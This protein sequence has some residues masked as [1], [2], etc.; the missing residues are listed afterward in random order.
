MPGNRELIELMQAIASGD[1]AGTS[2]RLTAQPDLAAAQLA[3]GSSKTADEFF[4]AEVRLQIYVGDSALHVAAAAYDVGMAEQL[5]AAGADVRARNRRGAEPIH[6][7]MTG[8]PGSPTWD[9][10]RQAAMIAYLVEVGA[11][12]NARAA[13]GVTPLH[14]AVRN[15]CSAAVARLLELGADP[16]LTN[17]SGSTALSLAGHTTGRGGSGS[18]QAKAEQAAILLLLEAA[19]R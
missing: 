7:A 9:P 1:A 10:L 13:G 3:K 4:L 2:R 8:G 14:R 11:D 18:P 16:Q 15:R 17:D 12:P 19:I 6:A 5:M